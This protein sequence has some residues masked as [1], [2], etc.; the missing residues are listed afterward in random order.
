MRA[1]L[2][3]PDLADAKIDAIAAALNEAADVDVKGAETH[4]KTMLRKRILKV[5]G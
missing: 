1:I 4:E 3:N 2:R 5:L